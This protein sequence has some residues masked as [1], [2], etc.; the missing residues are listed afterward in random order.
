MQAAQRERRRAANGL[1]ALALLVLYL[2]VNVATL[3][4]YGITA[5]EPE[6]WSFGDRYYRYYLTFD[7]RLLDFSSAWWPPTNT[8]PVGPTLAALT[9][10]LFSDRLGLLDR[11]D[12][13]HLASVIL[14]G[15][16]LSG[17]FMFLATHAGRLTAG[18]SC[19]ALALQ[20]RVWGEAH[21]NSQDIA[22]LAFYGVTVLTFL[23]GML[24]QRARWLLASGV[25]WGLALGSKINAL[26]VP[27][28]LAPMLVSVARH[29]GEYPSSI[30]R[31]L[32]AYPVIAA[33]ALFLAW[34]YFWLS[35]L[36]RLSRFMSYLVHWGY[37]GP[38]SWQAAPILN[39]LVT[40]PVPILVFG[41]FG[42]VASLRTGRPFESRVNLVLLAWL[43]VPIARSTLPGVLNYD[44]IRRFMEFSAALA[45]FSGIG[46]A[47]LVERRG[48][49]AKAALA[50]LFLV[51]GV[52]VWRYFPYESSYYNILVGGLGGAQALKLEQS[53]DYW[54]SSYREGIDW[55]NAHADPG[56]FLIIRHTPHFVPN[57]A[58]RKDLVLTRHL[59][60]DELPATGR[61]VYLMYVPA[62][63]YDYN[64]CLA[65]AF[66]HP[67]YEVRRG[68]GIILRIYRLAAESRL[69]VTRNALPPPQEFSATPAGRWVAFGWKPH[70]SGDL[71]GHILY[72]GRA[73]G[74][75]EA[76]ACFRE[77]PS[78]VEI[79]AGV[80]SGQYYLSLSVLTR[81]AE[82]S[83][84]TAEIRRELID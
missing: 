60:M 47:S 44:L 50:A 34:P 46:G 54:L 78:G 29:P 2:T 23:H 26:S 51:P 32:V 8:W 39:V 5:D 84:R 4:R 7:P 55:V 74:R 12:G 69:V 63:P 30:K 62:E 52:A 1:V 53:T 45:I 70:A 76:S 10:D 65:E 35:P 11:N 31:S 68:G 15:V 6:H 59:W 41:L 21:N 3:H 75:Y 72:Y 25:C 13:R 9:A 73:P 80:A 64:M 43:L 77:K 82:E 49:V 67:V 71:I 42:I 19:L 81:R 83:E 38:P 48:R 37:A 16:L 18:L 33:S 40:T 56:S 79:F 14:F 61:A 28:V 58:I 24:A 36:D 22:H 17:L 57:Y 66:L 20:P 27:I